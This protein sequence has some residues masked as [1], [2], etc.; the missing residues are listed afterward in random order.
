M[1]LIFI[2]LTGDI[3]IADLGRGLA[4]R[5]RGEG[6]DVNLVAHSMGGLVARAAL[7]NKLDRVP[8]IIQLGT[9]NYGSF[10]PV[11]VLRA[12][13][14]T[15]KRISTLD[16]RHSTVDLCNQVFNTFLGL[17]QMLPA[18]R[19]STR[20]SICSTPPNGR[21]PIRSRCRTC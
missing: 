16:L 21:R 2:H 15:V 10:A 8:R 9:P 6:R 17:Y 12:T 14:D 5:I 1:M 4:D 3:S 7:K 20:R 13:Y 11:E 19:P 18:L